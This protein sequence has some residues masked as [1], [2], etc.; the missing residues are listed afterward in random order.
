MSNVYSRRRH[1]PIAA[2]VTL[3]KITDGLPPKTA[4]HMEKLYDLCTGP[5][6]FATTMWSFYRDDD[7]TGGVMETRLKTQSWAN[8]L[9]RGAVLER[10]ESKEHALSIRDRI[11]DGTFVSQ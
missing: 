8:R 5:I 3:Q 7:V 11:L 2:S 10:L 6:V 1:I 9:S 4:Q